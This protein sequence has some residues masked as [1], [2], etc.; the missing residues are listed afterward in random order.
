M[1]FENTDHLVEQLKRDET[2]IRELLLQASDP[3]LQSTRGLLT[4]RVKV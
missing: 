2:T 1:R 3:F 4:T